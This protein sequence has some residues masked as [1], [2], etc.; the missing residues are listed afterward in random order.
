MV[1]ASW[2]LVVSGLWDHVQ[3]PKLNISMIV[4]YIH[5]Y[6]AALQCGRACRC[7]Q[8]WLGSSHSLLAG[9]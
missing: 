6:L 7:R 3:G 2:G 5:T 8:W 1:A 4:A 9:G